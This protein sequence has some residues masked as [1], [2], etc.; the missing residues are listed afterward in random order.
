MDH[1]LAW[2]TD[3]FTSE[4]KLRSAPEEPNQPQAFIYSNRRIAQ[5]YEADHTG[6]VNPTWIFRWGWASMI[7]ASIQA[8]WPF[9]RWIRA[10][11]VTYQNH[12]SAQI[13]LSLFPGEEVEVQ[14][15]LCDLHRVRGTWEH[16]VLV[17]GEVAAVDLAAGV[18]LNSAGR[19]SPPPEGLMDSIVA[20]HE[21]STESTKRGADKRNP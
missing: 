12:R 18:F 3:P 11:F 17:G 14:S 8:G 16:R 10:G 19:I 20:G 15:R 9:E 5:P 21:V 2:P 7:F 13:L 4:I 1:N 6:R